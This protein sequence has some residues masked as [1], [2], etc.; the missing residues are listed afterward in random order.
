[1][2]KKCKSFHKSYPPKTLRKLKALT[3]L[4][5]ELYCKTIQKMITTNRII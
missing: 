3:I 2:L 4:Q 5:K 1:M